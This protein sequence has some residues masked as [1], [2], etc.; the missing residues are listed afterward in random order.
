MC[1]L[2]SLVYLCLFMYVCL[3][4]CCGE[5]VCFEFFFFLVF[6]AARTMKCDGTIE[7][8]GDNG[9]RERRGGGRRGKEGVEKA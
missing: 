4:S 2:F 8:V 7:T 5:K 9:E 3:L 6:A 1:F